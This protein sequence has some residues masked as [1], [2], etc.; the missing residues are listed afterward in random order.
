MGWATQRPI[1]TVCLLLCNIGILLYQTRTWKERR[2]FLPP[3][4]HLHPRSK[5][6]IP[7][8]TP[9][10]CTIYVLAGV[11]Y[12]L[13]AMPTSIRGLYCTLAVLGREMHYCNDT[14]WVTPAARVLPVAYS[15]LHAPIILLHFEGSVCIAGFGCFPLSSFLF[16]GYRYRI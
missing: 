9:T 13:S 11:I 2:S 7:R 14:A 15:R 16:I 6:L 3:R 4:V 5:F 8:V 10:E 12:E 1:G